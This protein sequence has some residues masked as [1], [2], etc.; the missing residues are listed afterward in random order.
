ML[1]VSVTRVALLVAVFNALL[2]VPAAWAIWW[3][4]IR[5]SPRNG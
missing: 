4:G 5:P 2:A 1:H 3:T